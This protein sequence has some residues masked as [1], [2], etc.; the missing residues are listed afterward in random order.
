V[1]E[2][3]PMFPLGTVLLPGAPLPLQVF[4]P[5]YRELTRDCLAGVP[6]FGVVL[7]ERGS[8][9]GGGEVR[10][11][12]GTVARIVASQSLPDGRAFLV[13]VGTRR[14]RVTEWLEDAPYPRAMVEELV[15]EES[16]L[17]SPDAY[18]ALV[19]LARRSLAL[20]AELGIDAGEATRDFGDEPT[21]GTFEIAA[22]TPLGVLDRQRVL[23]RP[24]AAERCTLLDEL[25]SE[26]IELLSFR[27]GGDGGSLDDG[28]DE[29]T[30]D[31]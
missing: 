17:P 19:A 5:R 26:L 12:V 25:L 2:S 27:L 3:L 13:T 31:T 28:P 1:A 20:A 29:A 22:V 16:S 7:I 30:G 8:E 15:D 21:L 24:S 6:E 9:V 11:N 23:S 14:I 10:T 18:A 4:E